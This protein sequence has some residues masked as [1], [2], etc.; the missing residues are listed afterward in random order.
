[1]KKK[2]RFI[3]DDDDEFIINILYNIDILLLLLMI[4]NYSLWLII[5]IVS[6]I[7]GGQPS[8]TVVLIDYYLVD[9]F[10][11]VQNGHSF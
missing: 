11:Q 4:M 2:Q 6:D 5:Y 8:D 3:T 1:M 10:T 9:I 7:D